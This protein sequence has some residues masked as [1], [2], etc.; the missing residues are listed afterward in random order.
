M[1]TF[2]KL[3][4]LAKNSHNHREN[5]IVS[6]KT[7]H[8]QKTYCANSNSLVLTLIALQLIFSAIDINIEYT[9]HVY[10]Q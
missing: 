8:K 1:T 5:T 3:I 10:L 4:F 7:L 6:T 2:I 9:S